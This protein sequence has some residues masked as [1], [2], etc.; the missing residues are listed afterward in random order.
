MAAD[1]FA[2]IL[3]HGTD[4]QIKFAQTRKLRCRDEPRGK[5]LAGQL[6]LL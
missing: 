1:D 2:L 6:G 3:Q 5:L 4:V